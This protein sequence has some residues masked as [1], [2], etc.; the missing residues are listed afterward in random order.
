MS[1]EA[2]SDAWSRRPAPDG[3]GGAWSGADGA[4]A[5]AAVEA[6]TDWMLGYPFVFR[7][8][9]R[10]VGPGPVLVD[11]GCG[12]GRVADRAARLLGA[13]VVG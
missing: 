5:F 8:L 4:E 11:Y 9:S 12:P 13:R 3:E 1:K 10:R 2:E 7:A 6:A